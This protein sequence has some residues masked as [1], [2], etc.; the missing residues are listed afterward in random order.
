MLFF[1]SK[2]QRI[3]YLIGPDGKENVPHREWLLV[4]DRVLNEVKDELAQKGR[5]DEFIGSK[6]MLQSYSKIAT[7]T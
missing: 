2:L 3:R 1:F 6:V 5:A 7:T 4:Y